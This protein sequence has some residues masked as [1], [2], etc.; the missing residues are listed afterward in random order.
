MVGAL[1]RQLG[2]T[3]E[4]KEFHKRC[5]GILADIADAEDTVGSRRSQASGLLSVTAAAAFARRQL[6]RVVPLFL[7]RYPEMTVEFQSGQDL[8][9]DHPRLRHAHHQVGHGLAEEAGGDDR[10]FRSLRPSFG[11]V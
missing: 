7:Q 8:V 6:G 2:M 1:R 3:D 4:G 11:K 9:P 10:A 5:V